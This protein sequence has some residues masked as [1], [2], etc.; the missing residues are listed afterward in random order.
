MRGRAILPCVVLVVAGCSTAKGSDLPAPS[1]PSIVIAQTAAVSKPAT[2]CARSTEPLPP[3]S[4]ADGVQLTVS[5]DPSRTSLL[6]KNTG[7]LTV[8]V[9]PDADFRSR[10]IAAPYANPKD[11]ASRNALI[12]VNNSG[13]AE[14]PGVPAYVPKSQLITL[15]PQWAICALTDNLRETASVRYLQDRTS[16]AQYFVAKAL[17]DQ[18]LLKVSAGRSRQTLIRCSRSTASTL[19][20]SPELSDI[21]LYVEIVGPSSPCRTGYRALLH[22]DERATGQ[23]GAAVLNRLSG[24]PR[25][26]P[27]SPLFTTTAGS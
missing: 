14:L 15:P 16:S 19:K 10:L 3:A 12:A 17:A 13:G 21:E 7:S 4:E 2:D 18:L 9:L 25:L 22:D 8:V 24:V 20:A 1:T 23:L 5:T 6:L 26:L 27:N 11:A